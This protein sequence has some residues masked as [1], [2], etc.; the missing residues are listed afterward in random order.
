MKA[1]GKYS[2]IVSA[3]PYEIVPD[4]PTGLSAAAGNQSITLS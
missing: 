4:K 2:K 3:I 1:Y